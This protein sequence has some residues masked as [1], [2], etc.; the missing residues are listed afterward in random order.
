[1]IDLV[2]LFLL[3]CRV[4]PNAKNQSNQV[5]DWYPK[6]WVDVFED[7]NLNQREILPARD[8][9]GEECSFEEFCRLVKVP[10]VYQTHGHD[11]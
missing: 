11:V 2:L 3:R 9:N 1:M 6:S 5:E 8:H 10:C 7:E 4:D